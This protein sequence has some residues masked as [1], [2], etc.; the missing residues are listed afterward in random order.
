MTQQEFTAYTGYTPTIKQFDIINA[1]YMQSETEK[2]TFC[3]SWKRK[4][5]IATASREAMHEIANLTAQVAELKM[6]LL[7]VQ[8]YLNDTIFSS[9]DKIDALDDK[10]NRRAYLY[11]LYKNLKTIFNDDNE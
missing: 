1:E 9:L 8:Y 6:K 10:N 11:E 7:K 3:A 2:S 5:G 4:G